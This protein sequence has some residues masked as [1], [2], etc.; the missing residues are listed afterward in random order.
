MNLEQLAKSYI[1]K[2]E[3]SKHKTEEGEIISEF[4]NEINLERIG[5]KFRKVNF[6]SV[7]TKLEAIANN[8]QAMREFL[9]NCKDSKSRSGS[10]SKCFYG[11]LKIK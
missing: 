2:K 6:M 7:R 10:F 8:K 11:A 1:L 9:S 5:T 4:M 3:K